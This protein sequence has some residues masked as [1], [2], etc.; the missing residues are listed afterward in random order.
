MFVA[1]LACGTQPGVG[2]AGLDR[3][4]GHAFVE[5]ALGLGQGGLFGVAGDH[6]DGQAE[7]NLTAAP[8]QRTGTDVGDQR[9]DLVRVLGTHQVEVGMLGRELAGGFR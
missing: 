4:L 8:L 2:R 7:A 9:G 1:Q 3:A 6:I 5:E